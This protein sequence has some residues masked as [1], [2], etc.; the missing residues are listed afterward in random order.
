MYAS[1]WENLAERHNYQVKYTK[2]KSKSS[3]DANGKEKR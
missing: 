3:R 2:K 1:L